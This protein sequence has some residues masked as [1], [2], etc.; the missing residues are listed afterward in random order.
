LGATVW[1]AD[2]EHATA[3]AARIVAGTVW[4]N[5]LI[6]L[7]PDIPFGGAKQSGIGRENG[8]EGMKEYTQVQIVSVSKTRA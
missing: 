4:V 5:R 7:P 3:V 2:Q 1:G 8:I 6:D